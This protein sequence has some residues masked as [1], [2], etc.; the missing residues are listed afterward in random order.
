[1]RTIT[2]D[3]CGYSENFSD[4]N[5]IKG[6]EFYCIVASDANK[7]RSEQKLQFDLC[8]NCRPH[9]PNLYDKIADE[10]VNKMSTWLGSAEDISGGEQK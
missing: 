6:V 8:S 1:M 4:N 3:R 2:C 5:T 10:V 9:L 7:E